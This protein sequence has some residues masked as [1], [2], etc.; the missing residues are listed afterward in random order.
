MCG[1]PD[2]P[3]VLFLNAPLRAIPEVDHDVLS[4]LTFGEGHEHD[5][6]AW[7]DSSC[8]GTMLTI[9]SLITNHYVKLRLFKPAPLPGPAE[10]SA[11][12]PGFA[13]H[14]ANHRA[15]VAQ[16]VARSELRDDPAV[17]RM[18]LDLTM[19]RVADDLAVFRDQRSR[20]FIT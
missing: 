3:Q 17:R 13:E 10:P 5:F 4:A 2:A 16:V 7:V 8:Q 11:Q 15:H 9:V 6:F 14:F 12:R 18:Q 20:R 19:H 1:T